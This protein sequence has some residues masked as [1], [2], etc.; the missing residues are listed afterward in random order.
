MPLFAIA[1]TSIGILLSRALA[2]VIGM[3]VSFAWGAP[4]DVWRTNVSI[5]TWLKAL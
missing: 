5:L 4:R 3:G 2:V 1:L